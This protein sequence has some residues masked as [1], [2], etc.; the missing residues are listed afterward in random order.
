METTYPWSPLPQ[1]A[2]VELEHPR[3]SNDTEFLLVAELRCGTHTL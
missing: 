2:H 3:N 1:A